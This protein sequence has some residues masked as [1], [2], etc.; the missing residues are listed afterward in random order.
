[1]NDA[2]WITDQFEAHRA[3]LRSVAYRMLG[4]WNEADDAVQESWLRLSRSDANGIENIGGWLTTV[5][6]RVCLDMLRSRKSRRE[7]SMEAHDV[8]QSRDDEAGGD[9]EREAI[10]ADSIGIALLVVLGT[11]NPEERIAFVLHDIFAV[12]YAEIAPIVGRS[13]T[14][15]RQL[16][17]RARRRI[18]GAKA[19]SGTD[20]GVQRSLVDS[21]LAAARKGDFDALLSVL[22]P[23]VVLRSD[24]KNAPNEVR[25]VRAVAEQ[26]MGG[27]ARAARPALVNGDVGVVVSPG[28]Q[29]LL[30]LV[31]SY[32]NGKIVG[33]DVVSEASRVKELELVTL[34]E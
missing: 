21:F 2:Y 16:A 13:E 17:S 4:N 25:G 24:L 3:H 1:M 19:S 8:E 31:L 12:P 32:E 26:L 10:L 33:V 15:T 22:D 18:Q 7:E 34:G 27:G 11:L 28:G 6:S 14:A 29:L 5:V 9:P 30:V 23:R 20:I